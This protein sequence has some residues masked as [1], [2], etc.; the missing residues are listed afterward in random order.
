MSRYPV[1]DAPCTILRRCQRQ[2]SL[3]I[4]REIENSTCKTFTS[5]DVEDLCRIVSEKFKVEDGGGRIV[6]CSSGM[7]NNL[8]QFC[9]PLRRGDLWFDL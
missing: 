1:V 4:I 3:Y 5:D 2:P 7:L 9:D 6:D 8:L